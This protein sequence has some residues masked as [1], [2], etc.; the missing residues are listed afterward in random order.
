MNGEEDG[1]QVIAALARR[2]RTPGSLNTTMSKVRKHIYD[3]NVRAAEY[4][5]TELEA[6]VPNALVGLGVDAFVDSSLREQLITQ[7]EHEEEPVWPEVEVESALQRVQLLPRGVRTFVLSKQV[8]EHLKRK[9]EASIVS[10]NERILY[11]KTDIIDT[12]VT[13]LKS[14]TVKSSYPKIAIPLLLLSGRRTS[15]IM[16][17][18]ST[19][20]HVPGDVRMCTFRG[21]LKKRGTAEV[22][23]IPLLCDWDTFARGI[24]ILREKQGCEKLGSIE[25][26]RRYQPNLQAALRDVLPCLPEGSHPRCNYNLQPDRPDRR[27]DGAVG[28]LHRLLTRNHH[29]TLTYTLWSCL[30][31]CVRGDTSGELRFA[32]SRGDAWVSARRTG[33]SVGAPYSAATTAVTQR[34]ALL[35]SAYRPPAGVS[36][37]DRHLR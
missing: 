25:C 4:D 20:T 34:K 3:N 11:V 19:F 28:S 31:R 26:K 16:N 33:A 14:A 12:C 35:S 32:V 29:S 8:H 2:Y 30:S 1:E 18:L 5:T 7:K 9:H 27:K 10:K 6:S 36:S 24:S 21:Q 23:T 22:Y 17:G 15:E 13:L 37:A